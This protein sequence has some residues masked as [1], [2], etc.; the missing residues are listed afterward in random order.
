M[1]SGD[2]FERAVE[3]AERKAEEDQQRLARKRLEWIARMNRTAFQIH[4]STYTAV[5][6][7]LIVIWALTWRFD[8]G[9]AYPWFVYPLLGWGIAVIVH[10]VVARNIWRHLPEQSPATAFDPAPFTAPTE[11]PR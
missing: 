3:R 7:L 4:A 5:Q 9:T 2:A 6:V 8:H 10:Y 11:E 1:M